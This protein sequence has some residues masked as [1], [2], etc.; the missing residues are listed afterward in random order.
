MKRLFLGLLIWSPFVLCRTQQRKP[1][2]AQ[3][4]HPA[5]FLASIPKC[6]SHLIKKALGLMGCNSFR[7]PS[8]SFFNA[9]ERDFSQQRS[10]FSHAP[11]N[12]DLAQFVLDNNYKGILMIRDPRDQAVSFVHF[13]QKSM[14][15]WDIICSLPF[16]EALTRWITDASIMKGKGKFHDPLLDNLGTISDFY[17]QYLLWTD[18][19][20]FYVAR[21]EN[22][23]GTQGGGSDELQRQELINIAHHLGIEATPEIFEKIKDNLFGRSRTFRKGQIGSWRKTFTD[24]HKKLFKEIAGD[25]LIDLGYEQDYSW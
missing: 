17:H 3:A 14:K 25:L 19:P 5:I 4:Q 20:N 2:K 13:A 24:E 8:C 6:G 12:D 11:H 10:I 23:V 1:N 9:K 18:Q 22:L 16:N 15:V 21:F 7:Y